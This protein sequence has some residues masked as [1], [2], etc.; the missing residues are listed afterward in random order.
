MI[1]W[2]LAAAALMTSAPVEEYEAEEQQISGI[3]IGPE[4]AFGTLAAEASG[5]L[6]VRL[7]D[8]HQAVAITLRSPARGLTI[9]YSLPDSSDGRGLESEAVIEA[10]G[11]ELARAPLTSRYSYYYGIYPFTNRPSDGRA[12]HFWDE[13]RILLPETLPTGT[14][15]TLRPAPGSREFAVDV[16]ETEQVETPQPPPEG[17]ISVTEFGADP[18]GQ[19]SARQAFGRA[20]AA[21]RKSGR[22]LYVPAGRYRIDGHVVVDEVTIAGAGQWHTIIAGHHLGFYSLGSGSRRVSLSGFA[23]ESDV[24]RRQDRLPLAAIGG[25]F[26][27]SEFRDLYLHHAKVGLWLDGPAHDLAIREVT[28]ADQAADGINLHRG[29]RSAVIENNRIRNVG[30]DGIASWSDRVA[31]RDI[32]IR[33]NRVV[34]PGLANGIA[35]YGGRDIEVSGNWIADTLTQGGGIHLGTR[36]RSTPFEGSIRVANNRIVR[37]GSMDPNWHFGIGAIWLYAL[38]KPIAA[39]IILID[40]VIEDAGCEAVQLIGPHRIDGISIDGLQIRGRGTSVFALQTAGS[41]TARRIV[42]DP[43]TPILP[44]SVPPN[45]RLTFGA[46]N[47]GWRINVIARS[48]RPTCE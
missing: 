27:E 45:L 22:V 38:E 39:N 37:S 36:F 9:R 31:N 43:G 24:T 11:R 40:N 8:P 3:V 19:R 5:R 14:K 42:R 4:R 26:S 25:I 17:A 46:G 30:D 23:I 34:A 29:I 10:D 44:E 1:A 48:A 15:L 18:T 33:R 7:D 28:I 6:A 47:R 35:L 21:A 2:S 41:L 20:V 32:L 13:V 16:I 12:H